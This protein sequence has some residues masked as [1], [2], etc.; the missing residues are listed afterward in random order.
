MTMRPPEG[1]D[2]GRGGGGGGMNPHRDAAG[3][4]WHPGRDRLAGAASTEVTSPPPPSLPAS[5]KTRKSTTKTRASECQVVRSETLGLWTTESTSR[6]SVFHLD[7][8]AGA[9]R[10]RG[11]RNEKE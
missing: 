6:R 7:P 5:Q 8:V 11:V 3:L 2:W 1:L 9:R 10:G 4:W